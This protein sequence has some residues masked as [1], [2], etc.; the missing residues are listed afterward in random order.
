MESKDGTT[1][2][3][4]DDFR[5][6]DT[7]HPDGGQEL[8]AKN[9]YQTDHS[10]YKAPDYRCL[11]PKKGVPS[12][13]WPHFEMD[14]FRA[15]KTKRELANVKEMKFDKY[16]FNFADPSILQEM[17]D[18]NLRTTSQL[19]KDTYGFDTVNFIESDHE[20]D[21]GTPCAVDCLNAEF[22]SFAQRCKEAGGVFKCCMQVLLVGKFDMVRY[23][24]K[25][26]GLIET[27]PSRESVKCGQ[28]F[29]ADGC[30]M[31]TTTQFCS[32]KVCFF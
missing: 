23:N 22:S 8:N 7:E 10:M 12:S 24:L 3:D 4:S 26:W 9:L 14:G 6:R 15:A 32:Y 18:M 13:E 17:T 27:G 1:F 11:K 5:A 2:L 30:N 16:F 31:C 29:V 25:R 21:D 28:G 20:D 19:W